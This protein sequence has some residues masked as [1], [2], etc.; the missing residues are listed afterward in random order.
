MA[1]GRI[2]KGGPVQVDFRFPVGSL[3]P[4][5]SSQNA[6]LAFQIKLI[7][8][9]REGVEMTF[10][11]RNELRGTAQMDPGHLVC[12]RKNERATTIWK[13]CPTMG[14]VGR[15][16]RRLLLESEINLQKR[17]HNC[18]E[19]PCSSIETATYSGVEPCRCGRMEPGLNGFSK[20]ASC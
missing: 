1:N 10:G 7:D 19:A 15:E 4:T 16:I 11:S 17:F 2:R 3:D 12:P 14:C 8:P 13:I 20:T 9:D 6:A 5:L 18:G